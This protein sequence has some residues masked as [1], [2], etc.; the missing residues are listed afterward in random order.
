M[1]KKNTEHLQIQN[2]FSS[3]C[4]S[5]E[6]EKENMRVCFLPL[7]R[8]LWGFLF[9]LLEVVLCV[10]AFA[11]WFWPALAQGCRTQKVLAAT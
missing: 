8:K 9:L 11:E 6:N 5:F 3:F 10:H 2:T 4:Y 7:F 1:R